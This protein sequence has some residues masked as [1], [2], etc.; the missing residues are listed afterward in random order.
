MKSKTTTELRDAYYDC[1]KCESGLRAL[2]LQEHCSC[3][4]CEEKCESGLR[5]LGLQKHC[6]CKYCGE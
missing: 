5:A 1:F 6:S 4:Y 3:K 2:G